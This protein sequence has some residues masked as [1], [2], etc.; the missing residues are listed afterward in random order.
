M[1]AQ[2][3][4]QILRNVKDVAFATVDDKGCPKVRIIDVMLVE[5][6]KLY[7]CTARGKNFYRQ[8]MENGRVAITGLNTRFQMVRLE[9]RAVR[10][11]EQKM[12]VSA[13]AYAPKTARYRQSKEEVN[14]YDRR[15]D[16]TFDRTQRFFPWTSMGTSSDFP[17]SYCDRHCGRRSGGNMHQR[18]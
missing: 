18:I 9:G 11:S 12:D 8:L 1:N 14:P 2:E 4:L 3:C 5:R 13:A 10:L 17:C 6:G 15:Y 7:F 16:H